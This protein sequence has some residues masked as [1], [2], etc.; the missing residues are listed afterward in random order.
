MLLA[1]PK[2]KQDDLTPEQKAILSELVKRE[3]GDG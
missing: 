3:L 1:Y 2:S